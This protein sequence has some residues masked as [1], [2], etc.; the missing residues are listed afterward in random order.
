MNHA[1][2]QVRSRSLRKFHV[3]RASDALGIR[4]QFLQR[5][6]PDS[7]HLQLTTP[8]NHPSHHPTYPRPT[9]YYHQYR[10]RH[11]LRTYPATS[12][13]PSRKYSSYSAVRSCIR[14]PRHKST[15]CSLTSGCFSLGRTPG[16]GH[17]VSVAT[18]VERQIGLRD[19]IQSVKTQARQVSQQVLR[20]YASKLQI[21]VEVST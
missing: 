18:R 4:H 21:K 3:G 14:L 12:V 13:W 8:Q 10:C 19:S 2:H 20:C 16:C 15:F 6:S 7:P 9:S 5:S 17:D 11:G 1:I